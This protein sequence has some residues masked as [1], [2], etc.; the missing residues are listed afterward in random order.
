M[1]CPLDTQAT[2]GGSLKIG[3][4]AASH[5]SKAFSLFPEAQSGLACHWAPL[6]MTPLDAKG[7]H[8]PSGS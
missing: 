1:T 4:G 2:S 8:D 6:G 7:R 3:Q 5:T